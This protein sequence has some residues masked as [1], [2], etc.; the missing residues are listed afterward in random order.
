VSDT[1]FQLYQKWIDEV[2]RLREMRHQHTQFNTSL[3]LAV[4][5]GLSFFLNKPE[6]WYFSVWIAVGMLLANLSW[7]NTDG[8]FAHETKRKFEQLIELERDMEPKFI[9]RDSQV[10]WRRTHPFRWLTGVEIVLPR[11]FFVTFL[12]IA[13]KDSWPYLVGLKESWFS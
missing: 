8:W 13:I 1:R 6:Q 9:T 10:V 5:G 4:A 12:A 7:M 11:L 2:A 3:N